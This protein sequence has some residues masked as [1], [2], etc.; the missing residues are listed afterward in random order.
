MKFITGTNRHQLHLFPVTIDASISPDN[1]VRFIEAFVNS[2]NL[3]EMGFKSNY[4]ENGR[5][6]YHPGDLLKLFIYGYL[7]KTRSSRDLEK[8]C[9]RN[10]E[11]I[12]LMQG[13][14]P[15]HN[16]I[17]NF[18][19][20]NPKA[21]K[22]VFRATVEV[23]RNFDLIG[24]SL[25]AGDSTKLRAQN[26]KKNNFNVKKIERHVEYIDRKIDEFT[27]ALATA[28]G[29]QVQELTQ[30]IE[31]QQERK[32]KYQEI[33]KQLEES[34]EV[35]VS[36]SDPDSRM[37]ITRNNI[38]EVAYN[39]QT[40]VD[41]K[42]FIPIDYEVTNEN[43][44]RAMGDMT[45]RATE[46]LGTT[47]FTLLCDKGYH[48]GSELK[49]AQELGIETIVAIPAISSASM[50][51]DPAY[52]VSEFKY[53]A[54]DN[55]YTCP[56]GN[57]LTTN[58]NWYK[59]HHRNVKG[60]ENTVQV[61]HY[62]SPACKTCPVLNLCT[63]NTQGRGRVIERSEYAPYIEKNRQNVK[64]KERLYKQRQAIVEHP[65]GVLKRQW[66][67]YY[68]STKKWKARASADAGLMFVAYN[69]RRLLTILGTKQLNPY[70]KGLYQ[71]LTL[72]FAPY[73]FIK[74]NLSQYKNWDINFYV[75]FEVPLKWL[76]LKRI[77]K[78]NGGF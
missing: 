43:D 21:I 24:G 33:S 11:V 75:N 72:F 17:S 8:E 66:G 15:D 58:G 22:K 32:D 78:T 14:S 71:F 70:L 45:K 37:L 20:D 39:V 28:D 52:N 5:P 63:K 6:A 57:T 26:S 41:A 76:N 65:Y 61:Q 27:T 51:P 16:T 54:G 47:D 10:I 77:L 36:T 18:R 9:T 34:G 48:T 74:A 3:S 64:E 13:L 49:T 53:D 7:N 38:T 46:I 2:L 12:W 69:L 31:I 42:H 59:K 55:T 50:A 60:K 44:S 19:R 25:I 35:Q 56:Q 68:I 62:K 23:A 29:D 40:T 67:F 30:N 4:A 73:G 1:E